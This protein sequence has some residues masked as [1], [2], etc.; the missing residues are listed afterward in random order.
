MGYYDA[1]GN[2]VFT[3]DDILDTN[4]Q[5]RTG[6]D[7]AGN[8]ISW[9]QGQYDFDRR[10]A[11]LIQLM[12]LL[13]NPSIAA[14]GNAFGLNP[15]QPPAPIPAPP[16]VPPVLPSQ[17]SP[18]AQQAVLGNTP[19]PNLSSMAQMRLDQLR[20]TP[21]PQ[22]AEEA[23]PAEVSPIPGVTFTLPQPYK[24]ATEAAGELIKPKNEVA[25][26]PKGLEET[27]KRFLNPSAYPEQPQKAA[28]SIPAVNILKSAMRLGLNK[29][30][31][32][33]VVEAHP[34]LSPEVKE[35][36]IRLLGGGE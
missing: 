12:G 29:I 8:P 4:V 26:S 22:P 25:A 31:V 5:P 2:Y 11:E 10:R 24:A 18:V 27:I 35:E 14:L 30:S 32:R 7:A 19:Q 34:G 3:N 15:E 28:V 23:R 33:K 16:A 6:R 13:P 20:P 21:Q 1:N 17:A 9:L 36:L